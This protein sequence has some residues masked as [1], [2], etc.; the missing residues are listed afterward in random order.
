MGLKAY[1]NQIFL[2]AM[3]SIK[4]HTFRNYI[5]TSANLLDFRVCMQ[6]E[7]SMKVSCEG[8]PHV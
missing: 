3:A 7:R 8:G 5:A 4:G 1:V 6:S 2:A